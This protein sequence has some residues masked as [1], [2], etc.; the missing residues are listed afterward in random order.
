M[1]AVRLE[2]RLISNVKIAPKK[3][4]VAIFS[5]LAFEQ[6]LNRELA[7]ERTQPLRLLAGC[8]CN[9]KPLSLFP[10]GLGSHFG[11][12]NEKKAA[13]F[14]L[15]TAF[16]SK[17]SWLAGQDGRANASEKQ[18]LRRRLFERE[19]KLKFMVALL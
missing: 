1:R 4:R 3:R 14:E 9:W 16:S 12:Y 11:E 5:L 6:V 13:C 8:R 19:G 17:L 10:L 2:V 7:L 15:E 18:A